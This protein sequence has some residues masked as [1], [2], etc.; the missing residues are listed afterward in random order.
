MSNDIEKVRYHKLGDSS[1]TNIFTVYYLSGYRTNLTFD[2]NIA[3]NRKGTPH[4]LT[5]HLWLYKDA[6][7]ETFET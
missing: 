7:R 1:H 6:K 3:T 2:I 5:G 4:N